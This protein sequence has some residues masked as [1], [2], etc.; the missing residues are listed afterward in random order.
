MCGLTTK[1][2]TSL[3]IFYHYRWKIK[4]SR[5]PAQTLKDLSSPPLYVNI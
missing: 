2:L 4:I 5:T 3:T 1:C